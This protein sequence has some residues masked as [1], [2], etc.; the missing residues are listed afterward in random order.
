MGIL[1][2]VWPLRE[3]RR[4]V[5]SGPRDP[6]APFCHVSSRRIIYCLDFYALEK[7][8]FDFI[9]IYFPELRPRFV[10]SPRPLSLHC[11][12]HSAWTVHLAEQKKLPLC[13]YTRYT[14]QIN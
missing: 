9:L 5:Y 13:G 11:T 4:A 3:L 6:S 14:M 10:F 7:S 12:A 1:L 2:S 8:L